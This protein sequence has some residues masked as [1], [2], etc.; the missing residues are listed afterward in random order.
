MTGTH[1]VLV[2]TAGQNVQEVVFFALVSSLGLS[3]CF[4]VFLTT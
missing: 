3:G 2:G 1:R 4:V